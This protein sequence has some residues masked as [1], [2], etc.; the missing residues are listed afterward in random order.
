MSSASDKLKSMVPGSLKQTAKNILGIKPTVDPDWQILQ[1]VGPVDEPHVVFDV[2]AYRGYF[3]HCWRKWC[4]KATVHAF[5]PTPASYAMLKEG[6]ASTENIHLVNAAVG[7][8]VG[9]LEMNVVPDAGYFNSFLAADQQTWDLVQY[10]EKKTI[11]H[12]VPVTTLDTYTK[13]QKINRIHLMKIDVQ[14]F[15]LEVFR[16]GNDTLKFTD[17]IL[18]EAG[19]KPFYKGA[20]LFTDVFAYLTQ[21]GFHL[22]G[23]RAW[24][25]GNHVLMEG[26][27]LFRRDELAGP[28][29]SSADKIVEHVG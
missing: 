23:F 29:D 10:P 12:M 15:E 6:F 1:H 13:A 17:H 18:V 27:M 7:S 19:I 9:E 3:I 4:P 22:M 5:E 21:Q 2:G 20:P 25:R 16:G 26:D 24:H 11:K 8:A 14:G 28:I